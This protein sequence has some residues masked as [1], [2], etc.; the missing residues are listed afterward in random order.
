[1][2]TPPL[3]AYFQRSKEKREDEIDA[4]CRVQRAVQRPTTQPNDMVNCE[5]RG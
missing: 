4:A 2:S 5:R 1:M 3:P